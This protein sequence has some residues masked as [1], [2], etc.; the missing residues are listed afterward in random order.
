MIR[1]AVDDVIRA[2]GATLVTGDA[3][4]CFEGVSIDSR[5]VPEGGMFVAF[6]GERVDGNRFV[7]GAL[8]NGASVA[9]VTA[10]P[11][12]EARAAA[13][14]SGGVIVRAANDDGEEFMLR[15][16]QA[17]RAANPQWIVVGVTGSV[18]K[19]TTKEMLAAGIGALKRVHATSGN[20]NNLLGVPLTLFAASAEDEVLVVEMGMNNAGE[21]QRIVRA[22]R[23]NVA[24]ITNVG[25]SHIGNL[26]SR[27]GIARAKAEVVSGLTDCDA[28]AATLVLS[29][30]DDYA[31]F[32]TRTF[33][34]PAGV[35]VLRVGGRSTT[36]RATSVVLDDDGMASVSVEV[37]GDDAA[38]QTLE[39]TLSLPGRAMVY[40]LL[41]A[42]GA[43]VALGLPC[44]AP[45][46]AICAMKAAHMRMEVRQ[47]GD[48]ARVIDDTYNASPSSMAAALDVLCS[49]RCEGRR[50]AVLGEIGELGDQSAHLHG[51]VGAYA[52]AKPIDLLVLIG[53]GDA[54]HMAEA[55]TTM[56]FSED[57][58]E[59]FD[60][61]ADAARVMVPLF[62]PNDLV[63]VKASR[64][65]ELDAFSKEV[66][67]A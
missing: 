20:F 15:L 23:P 13:E 9:V 14:A 12:D 57:K 45:F 66:L 64:A 31:D 54:R 58:L 61:V 48:S 38:T 21:L 16:A 7:A 11:S 42:L 34:E 41:S 27:E 4:T 25:T 67:G 49:M 18:G 30:G 39:G 24:V 32:I 50:V 36:V 3:T 62:G 55:A 19:T 28:C 47:E 43:I 1:F 53:T 17:W 56:G 44:D 35:R 10:D 2:T 60:T 22:A 8:G 29:D 59:R 52:A 6:A 51:L 63:L 5:A 46:D 65:A 33:A 37:C 26:G 40:D